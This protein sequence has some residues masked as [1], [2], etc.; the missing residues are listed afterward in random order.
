MSSVT[1]ATCMHIRIEE[2]T[3]ISSQLKAFWEIKSLGIT[4]EEPSDPEEEEALQRFENTTQFKNERYAVELPCRHEN[5]ELPDN[6]RIARRRFKGLK[7]RLRADVVFFQRHN[8][9]ME[10]YLQQGIVEEVIEGECSTSNIK[11]HLPHHAVLREDKPTTKLRVLFDASSHKNGFPSLN[12]CLLTGPNLNPDLL[13][14]LIRFRLHEIAFMADIKKAFLQISLAEIDRDAVRFLCLTAPPKEDTGEKLRMLRMTRVV[15][16]V[17]PTP[18]LLA[19]T[20]RKHLH[21]YGEQHTAQLIKESLYV[22]DM[23]SVCDFEEAV[24]VTTDARDIMAA[25]GMDLCKWMTNSAALKERWKE[26]PIGPTEQLE[27]H[28]TLLKVLGLVWRTQTDDFV[29]DFRP[30][31]KKLTKNSTKR[32]ILQ[33]T[34]S[35]VDPLGFLTPF[36]I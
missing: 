10:D 20:V 2:D 34:A 15:F 32:N 33:H 31:L 30:L 6:Y 27:A 24:S 3:L 25:A 16:G 4:K 28:G 5:P 8:E 9:V 23:A 36:S 14:I 11:Y 18:F 26:T 35:I 1:E 19:V 17:S 21:Q 22:D 29:F 13:G 12:N 7:R